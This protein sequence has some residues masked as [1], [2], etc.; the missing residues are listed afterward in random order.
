M[1]DW[2]KKRCGYDRRLSNLRAMASSYWRQS[3]QA[4]ISR[5]CDGAYTS[6]PVPLFKVR[7]SD[8]SCQ[9]ADMAQ[10]PDRLAFTFGV[11]IVAVIVLAIMT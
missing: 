2:I 6:L 4:S 8:T 9:E 10:E 7:R 1:L 3:A 11:V 5:E